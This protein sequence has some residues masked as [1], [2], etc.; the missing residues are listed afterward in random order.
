MDYVAFA[1]AS[2]LQVS[3]MSSWCGWR[4]WLGGVALFTALTTTC[5]LARAFQD[6]P[7]AAADAHDILY[8]GVHDLPEKL[9]PASA[10]TDSETQAVELLFESLIEARYDRELGQFYR[11]ELALNLP[12]PGAGGRRF[13]L[14]R[15]ARWSD[16]KPV[17][18]IDVRH[19]AALLA[20]S[21][22]APEWHDLLDEPRVE[23][24][25]HSIDFTYRRLP[26]D[27]LARLTFKVLPQTFK[28][29]ALYQADD[30]AFAAQPVGSGPFCYAG[31]QVHDGRTC[32]VFTANPHYHRAGLP[33]VREIRFFV[34]DNPAADFRHP[35]R[36]MH[37]LLDLATDRMDALK[38]A[39]VPGI[40]TLYS[41]RVNFLAVNHR[42]PALQNDKLRRALAH[43]IDRETILNARFRGIAVDFSH[44]TI[45]PRV[46]HPEL[47]H[48]LNGPYPVGSWPN[49]PSVPPEPRDAG[50]YRLRLASAQRDVLNF[51]QKTGVKHIELTLKYPNDDARVAAACRDIAD[52][53]ARLDSGKDLALSL[54]LV[55]LPPRQL[56]EAVD[57]RDYE[58]AYYHRDYAD[59]SYWLWPLFDT[60]R[61]ALQQGGSN[62]LG[63]KNDDHL[64]K[65]F[66]DIMAERDFTRLRERTH[67]L[68][69]HLYEMMPLIPLWQLDVHVT[70]HPNLSLPVARLDPLRIFAGVEDWTLRPRSAE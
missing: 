61:E 40:Q 64:E 33:H 69:A 1:T 2:N 24:D 9:S 45:S 20:R 51:A 26:L 44:W 70:I 8:V 54:K 18:S 47:H 4:F 34:S 53:V 41:R 21:G 11:P 17:T 7:S 13:G 38:A 36:P 16:G 48:A 19:T 59:E 60:R 10:W 58:L 37:L 68:H 32:A 66:R 55:P 6:R 3:F 63:Y 5:A 35:E 67:A 50:T 30:P 25:L 27:P 56:K 39:S 12:E 62:F 49:A 28:G 22:R 46:L 31:R 42:I 65:L 14:P 52:Q 23:N 15:D 29:K 57:G 43:A